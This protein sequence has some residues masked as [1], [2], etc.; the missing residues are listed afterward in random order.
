MMSVCC[1]SAPLNRSLRYLVRAVPA[2]GGGGQDRSLYNVDP[3][4]PA[5]RGHRRQ[6][7]AEGAQFLCHF[8]SLH[9][10]LTAEG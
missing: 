4:L 10:K 1:L 6:G 2:D 5:L 9:A 3:L 7:A 8:C